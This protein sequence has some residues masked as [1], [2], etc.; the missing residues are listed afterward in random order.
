MVIIV[1]QH[2]IFLKL[3]LSYYSLNS[4]VL[5]YPY[6]IVYCNILPYKHVYEQ[7]GKL[8]SFI[9]ANQEW[10]HIYEETHDLFKQ[11]NNFCRFSGVPASKTISSA[12][13]K[14]LILFILAFT[15]QRSLVM[16]SY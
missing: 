9:H 12:Y 7:E 2:N 16:P 6:L 4:L 10:K 15:P 8:I 5:S 3:P 11:C 1:F 14:I 13:N